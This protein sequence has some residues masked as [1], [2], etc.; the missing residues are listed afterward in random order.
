[1]KHLRNC[2][3]QYKHSTVQRFVKCFNEIVV[4][5]RLVKKLMR[6]HTR[7]ISGAHRGV[8][9]SELSLYACRLLLPEERA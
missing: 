4:I 5:A 8:L 6:P 1:M 7:S 9:D 3:L 2:N